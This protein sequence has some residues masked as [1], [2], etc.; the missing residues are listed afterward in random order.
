MSLVLL[1]AAGHSWAQQPSSWAG[2]PASGAG[3]F[4]LGLLNLAM[5]IAFLTAVARQHDGPAPAHRPARSP[6]RPAAGPPR[7][8]GPTTAQSAERAPLPTGGPGTLDP[9]PPSPAVARIPALR[10]SD[11]E[12]DATA[13]VLSQA[14]A[15]GRLGVD[16]GI[17][18]IDATYRA[19][20]RH[21]LASLVADL[22][23]EQPPP[24]LE[25]RTSCWRD[26]RDFAGLALVAA[27]L[28]QAVAGVWELW[29]VAAAAMVPLAFG[30]P[31]CR[32]ADPPPPPL[33]PPR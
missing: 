14:I 1:G 25:G 32:A 5:L 18:R 3:F 7:G 16:E 12:R 6:E 33:L 8:S 9:A 27:V 4:W 29:P 24:T 28:L 30:W 22:P 21:Q 23:A 2:T 19:H 17:D 15:S 26:L 10:A 31:S 20:Y 11:A 13:E